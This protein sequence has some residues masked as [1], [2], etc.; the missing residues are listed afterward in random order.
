M[1]YAT[2]ITPL[3]QLLLFAKKTNKKWLLPLLFFILIVAL[4]II[5]AKLSAVPVFMYPLL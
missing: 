2:M 1:P 5:T 3:R 4:F